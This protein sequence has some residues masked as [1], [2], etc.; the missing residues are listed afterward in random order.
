MKT[1]AFFL[2]FL[3][4]LPE[5]AMA[6]AVPV[7]AIDVGEAGVEKV[8][9][10]L[11]TLIGLE[12][13]GQSGKSP[14]Q[15]LK[16][17]GQ[18]LVQ[19]DANGTAVPV[20]DITITPVAVT[21]VNDD[22]TGRNSW[23][24]G[25]YQVLPI[26]FR[27]DMNLGIDH[28]LTVYLFSYTGGGSLPVEYTKG[29][30]HA[31]LE[32]TVNFLGDQTVSRHVNT[33]EDISSD[34]MEFWTFGGALGLGSDPNRKLSVRL[35]LKGETDTMDLA[36]YANT[37]R[38]TVEEELSAHLRTSAL[39]LMAFASHV[40]NRAST[41]WAPSSDYQGDFNNDTASYGAFRIGLSIR[42]R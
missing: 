20:Y 2:A 16:V 12:L 38:R 40:T 19:K 9:T 11:D 6:Q 35:S 32:F 24:S 37:H 14:V 7:P 3:L 33:G 21:F 1:Y 23:P 4:L 26:R 13:H 42:R 31:F 30:L 34:A 5:F 18:M 27:R 39:D 15:M 25:Y 28:S 36:D 10:Q 22:D 41:D 8:G 17:S 29:Y